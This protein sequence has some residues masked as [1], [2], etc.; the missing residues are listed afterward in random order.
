MQGEQQD[1]VQAAAGAA[2]RAV[3][4]VLANVHVRTEVIL[5]PLLCA[6]LADMSLLLAASL[7]HQKHI[8][9]LQLI[10]AMQQTLVKQTGDALKQ[11]TPHSRKQPRNARITARQTSLQLAEQQPQALG[12]TLD[13]HLTS[14][15][16][17]PRQGM[18][19]KAG[20]TES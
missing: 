1:D 10:S 7:S 18:D 4:S 14:V 2:G 16:K 13:V 19:V 8:P 17:R 12:G 3:D 15:A 6:V 20:T 9:A 11:Y 5:M